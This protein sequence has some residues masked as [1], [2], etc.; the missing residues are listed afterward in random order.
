MNL[1]K[2]FFALVSILIEIQNKSL[3]ECRKGILEQ[4]KKENNKWE[5]EIINLFPSSINIEEK[6]NIY[7]KCYR[8]F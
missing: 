2:G 6:M 7:D 4:I 5:K 8:T 3:I 1:V